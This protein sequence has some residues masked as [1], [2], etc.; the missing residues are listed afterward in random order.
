MFEQ[1]LILVYL[2]KLFLFKAKRTLILECNQ[3]LG[4]FMLIYCWLNLLHKC[5]LL[6]T[7]WSAFRGG[8][9]FCLMLITLV[10]WMLFLWPSV[11]FPF[12]LKRL[13]TQHFNV[14]LWWT[15]VWDKPQGRIYNTLSYT[16]L[17]CLLKS[18][19]KLRTRKV[20]INRLMACLDSEG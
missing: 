9:D 16:L 15:W 19:V 17:S 3:V 1:F 4:F 11:W 20:A 5:A 7:R 18:Q 8:V 14:I 12:L 10:V 13:L 6:Q 2:P